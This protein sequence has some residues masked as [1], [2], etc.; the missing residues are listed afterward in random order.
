MVLRYWLQVT[1]F[2]VV[3]VRKRW[4]ELRQVGPGF[5]ACDMGMTLSLRSSRKQL[6][7]SANIIEMMTSA[8]IRWAWQEVTRGGVEYVQNFNQ[9]T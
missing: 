7:S 6:T 2:S 5:R 4:Y 1:K 8:K 3:R 9:E